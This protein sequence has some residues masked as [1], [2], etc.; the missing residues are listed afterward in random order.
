MLAGVLDQ[1]PEVTVACFR[2][3]EKKAGG[4]YQTVTGEARK[5][6]EYKGALVMADGLRIP[7]NDLFALEGERPRQWI[8]RKRSSPRIAI[9][10][11][12]SSQA[13]ATPHGSY[14]CES[15]GDVSC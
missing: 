11:I 12:S 10:A 15:G 14:L 8:N 13:K 2:P 1:H 5:I 6:D 9:P 4:A 3:D 7:L